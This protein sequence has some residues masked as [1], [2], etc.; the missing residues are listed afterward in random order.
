MN[1][2]TM[3]QSHKSASD[4]VKECAEHKSKSRLFEHTADEQTYD[5]RYINNSSDVPVGFE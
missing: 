4:D 2:S 5:P 1:T 3:D